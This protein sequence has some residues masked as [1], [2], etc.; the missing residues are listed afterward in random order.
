MLRGFICSGENW[1]ATYSSTLCQKT[2][3]FSIYTSRGSVL[4]QCLGGRGDPIR[5]IPV[6]PLE[7]E[8]VGCDSWW[9]RCRRREK[10]QEKRRKNRRRRGSC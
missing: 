3:Y 4:W 2:G 8:R 10:C 9:R 5:P 6:D 1:R 7:S